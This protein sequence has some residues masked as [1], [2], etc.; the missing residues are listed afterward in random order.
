MRSASCLIVRAPLQGPIAL[1]HHFYLERIRTTVEPDVLGGVPGCDREGGHTPS[2]GANQSM[3]SRGGCHRRYCAWDDD[4]GGRGACDMASEEEVRTWDS[5][6]SSTRV[7]PFQLRRSAPGAFLDFQLNTVHAPSY[8]FNCASHA[9]L[10]KVKLVNDGFP[11]DDE[12]C[13][14]V[15]DDCEADCSCVW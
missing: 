15:C 11:V 5:M 10:R 1:P 13:S 2:N 8:K 12:S 3:S 7:A 4:H 6:R 14:I 9:I